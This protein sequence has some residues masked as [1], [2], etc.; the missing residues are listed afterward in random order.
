M[1][2]YIGDFLMG[3]VVGKKFTTIKSDGSPITLAG[4]PVVS[5]YKKG[6]TTESVTGVT[7]T[8][9]YDGK[10][11]LH[12]VSIDTGADAT[13]YARENEF[14]AVLTAGTVDGISVV[15]YTLF[16]FSIDNRTKSMKRFQRAEDSVTMGTVGSGS[17]QTSIVS[18]AL[19][20]AAAAT[21]QFKGLV[22]AFDK[23]TTSANLRGQ[24]AQITANTSA[25]VFTLAGSGLSHTPVSGDTFT[26]T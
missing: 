15:G 18:S 14:E 5:V 16:S 21:D 1:S 8:V 25:G 11:G 23:G 20:P 7:L 4:T 2:E 19:D 26:I 6:S 17:T 12:D 10:S 9:D 24:K 22:M 13:F 3:G